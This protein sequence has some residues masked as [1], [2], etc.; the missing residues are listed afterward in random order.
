M[1]KK[2]GLSLVAVGLCLALLL[3]AIPVCEAGPDERVVKIGTPLP[4]TG[5]LASTGS[6][7]IKVVGDYVRYINEQ[8]GI[9]GI[10]VEY[11]WE[12]TGPALIP[13]EISAYKRLRERGMVVYI[14]IVTAAVEALVRQLQRDEMPCMLAT[15]QSDL[16]ITKPPY[17]F[18]STPSE[19]DC[20][21]VALYWFKENWT[22]E[23]SPR[24]G[25]FTYDHVAGW[26][27]MEGIKWAADKLGFEYVGRETFPF[28][29]TIDTTTEWLRLVGKNPDLI[30]CGACGMGMAT[31]IKDAKR[32]EIQE[33]GITLAHWDE[34]TGD[35]LPVVGTD[36]D[37]WYI[38]KW[39][40][41]PVEKDLPGMKIVY[42]NAEKNRR[43]W[44]PDEIPTSYVL[45]HI[46]VALVIEGVRLAIEKVGF[47]NLT[48]RDVRDALAS[49][50]DFETGLIQPVSMSDTKP[51]WSPGEIMY[52]VRDAKIWPISDKLYE[53][54]GWKKFS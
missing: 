20:A 37:G 9:N 33:K 40:P 44:K 21:A 12:D 25:V 3:T 50:K 41:S 26:E 49:I 53:Y 29:G 8:G 43:G 28:T 38:A 15:Y 48:S 45:G 27:A 30:Y 7:A 52:Q 5:P 24:V 54:P 22:K 36:F 46:F 2:I 14:S 32:L 1:W 10:K 39:S 35:I 18:T 19:G 6:V 16:T 4:I 42:Q 23:R 17:V 31:M 34:C 13:R 11:V 51:Y 47:E